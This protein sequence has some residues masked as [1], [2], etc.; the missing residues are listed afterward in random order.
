MKLWS[1]LK[2]L[3]IMETC[4]VYMELES[5]DLFMLHETENEDQVSNLV[6]VERF[7]LETRSMHV[8]GI[9]LA[10]ITMPNGF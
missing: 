3:K 6:K 10:L 4:K 5:H 9:F 8:K 2:E 1:L 7:P